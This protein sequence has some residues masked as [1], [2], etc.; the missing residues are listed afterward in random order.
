MKKV[1]KIIGEA[2]LRAFF[3]SLGLC[4]FALPVAVLFTWL[5]YKTLV[6]VPVLKQHAWELAKTVGCLS[7]INMCFLYSA[8]EGIE[9]RIKRR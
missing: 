3:F 2:L 8:L 6:D 5:S 9:Q 7:F 1:F 4:F